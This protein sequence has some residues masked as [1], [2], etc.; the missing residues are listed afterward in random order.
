MDVKADHIRP[1]EE[2]VLVRVLYS[3]DS[4]FRLWS[5]I[6]N[7]HLE[8]ARKSGRVLDVGFQ[9]HFHPGLRRLKELVGTGM[10]GAIA[11]L[12][13]RV[14]LQR[15]FCRHRR[16]AHAKAVSDS[17][18]AR[19]RPEYFA[20]YLHHCFTPGVIPSKTDPAPRPMQ[21]V[22]LHMFAIVTA[23][24]VRASLGDIQV[25]GATCTQ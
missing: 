16:A 22:A 4:R 21:G 12:H 24:E 20:T 19:R 5:A 18:A 2:I 6:E 10:L 8:A 1:P 11:H 7:L 3:S 14:C 15:L 13:C 25:S 23:Q 17:R 9:L